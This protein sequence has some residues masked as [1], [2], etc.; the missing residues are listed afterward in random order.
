MPRHLRREEIIIIVGFDLTKSESYNDCD[1]WIRIVRNH[2]PSAVI[3][4]V[5]TK[6]DLVEER[7]V[8][9]EE[10]R[11]HFS[12]MEPPVPYRETSALTGEGVNELFEDSVRLWF[13]T[14]KQVNSNVDKIGED[15]K[16]CTIC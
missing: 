9:A 11:N 8:T 16:P 7:A 14:N 12:A 10:A 2:A 1:D 13:M 15:H 6:A 3:F 4:A 5:G